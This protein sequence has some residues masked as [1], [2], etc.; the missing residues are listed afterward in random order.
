MKWIWGLFNTAAPHVLRPCGACC[1]FVPLLFLQGLAEQSWAERFLFGT[2]VSW[3]AAETRL[4]LWCRETNG[5]LLNGHHHNRNGK[6]FI[7]RPLRW[8][9]ISDR[10]MVATSCHHDTT[11]IVGVVVAGGRAPSVSPTRKLLPKPLL[12]LLLPTQTPA[13]SPRL[14]RVCTAR[15]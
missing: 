14:L 7:F 15:C 11:P 13:K 8:P 2:L 6:Y 4:K 3:P 1:T 5:C 9:F 10:T 12:L